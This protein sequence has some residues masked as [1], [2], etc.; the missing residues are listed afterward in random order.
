MGDLKPLP[1]RITRHEFLIP[2]Y[3]FQLMFNRTMWLNCTDFWDGNAWNRS[4]IQCDLSRS[5]L[6]KL[7]E[8]LRLL[9]CYLYIHVRQ[10]HVSYLARLGC[11]WHFRIYLLYF[12]TLL[13]CR[14]LNFHPYPEMFL[15]NWIMY[16]LHQKECSYRFGWWLTAIHVR[17]Q[18]GLHTGASQYPPPPSP[19][20][21]NVLQ[22]CTL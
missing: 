10:D 17:S 20:D 22:I 18:I 15:Q 7:A 11:N 2:I 6:V 8:F 9:Y 19:C 4:E 3:N 13:K 14:V 21:S 12:I 16:S 5:P 1:L